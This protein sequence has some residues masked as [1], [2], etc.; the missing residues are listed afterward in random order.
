[1]KLYELSTNYSALVDIIQNSDDAEQVQML[2]DTLEAIDDEIEVKADQIAR[3]MTE[4][5]AEANAIQTEAKRLA[6]RSDKLMKNHANLKRYL[7]DNMIR[8]GK[9]KF[10]TQLFNFTVR[11]NA[12]SVQIVDESLIPADFKREVI[13]TKIDKKAIAEMLKEKKEVSGATLSY[14]KTLMIK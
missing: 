10:K 1:M 4:L 11:N 14:S 2:M 3:I 13:E 5:E 7:L 9:E 12:P 6:E 8:T